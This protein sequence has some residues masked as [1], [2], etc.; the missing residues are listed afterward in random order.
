M[1][2]GPPP[3]KGATQF[4]T[5]QCFFSRPWEFVSSSSILVAPDLKPVPS[6]QLPCSG[7]VGLVSM[8]EARSEQ[9]YAQSLQSGILC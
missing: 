1:G 9:I 7:L 5:S 2:L 3:R 8:E 6:S 4:S